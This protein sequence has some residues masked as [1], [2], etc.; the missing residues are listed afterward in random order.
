[1]REGIS[2]SEDRP[3][4]KEILD[5]RRVYNELVDSQAGLDV[6]LLD[7]PGA[8]A[9]S[10]TASPIVTRRQLNSQKNSKHRH[11]PPTQDMS[12]PSTSKRSRHG[13][14]EAWNSSDAGQREP[15]PSKCTS[16]RHGR[17]GRGH[18]AQTRPKSQRAKKGRGQ[19]K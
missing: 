14:E 12:G 18:H 15:E 9:R 8:L 3:S 11:E 13:V 4:D 6:S 16:P 17:R 10:M 2:P 19:G 5:A 7:P 1:M